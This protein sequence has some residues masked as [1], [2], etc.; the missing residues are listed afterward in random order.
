[1]TYEKLG[2]LHDLQAALSETLRLYPAVPLDSKEAAADDVLPDGTA[3]KK[4]TV[5]GYVPY[6]MGRMSFLWGDDA[7]E[8]RPERWMT[9]D[10]RFQA[11]PLF[12]FTAFQAG[13]RTCLGKDSA[14][15]QMKMTAALVLWFFRLR[16]VP[17]HQ[18]GYRTM[19]VLAMRYGLRVTVSPRVRSC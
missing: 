10:G 8:F 17:G 15:L 11:Q 9:E 14:Y 1:M 18:V 2:Q 4:G 5:T 16:L 12:K 7:E 3:V 6:A 13:P 19:L